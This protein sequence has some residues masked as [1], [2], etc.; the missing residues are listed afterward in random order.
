MQ[1]HEY[2]LLDEQE[3]RGPSKSSLKRDSHAMQDLGEEL[4]GLSSEKLR[5]LKLAPE[6]LEAVL[7]GRSITAHGGLKRQRKFIGKLLRHTEIEPIQV[8]LL[9]LKGQGVSLVRIQHQCERWR[10]RL[11][12]EGDAAVNAFVGEHPEAERQKLRQLIREA[13]A[14]RESAKPPRA[15]RVMFKYLKEMLAPI[16][17]DSEADTDHDIEADED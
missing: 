13:L 14:E 5:R 6:L 17:D 2:D 4:M 1:D 12:S 3:Y 11:L 16:A 10:D 15:A 8:K 7:V 9:E